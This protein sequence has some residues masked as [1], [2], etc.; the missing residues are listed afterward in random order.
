MTDCGPTLEIFSHDIENSEGGF[1]TP[2][3]H[4]DRSCCKYSGKNGA[5]RE[6]FRLK[7]RR[8]LTHRGHHVSL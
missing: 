3:H 4:L 6:T 2:P 1:I 7:S 8:A 5:L